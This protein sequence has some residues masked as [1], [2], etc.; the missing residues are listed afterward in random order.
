MMTSTQWTMADSEEIWAAVPPLA[1]SRG[2][3]GV[4]ESAS[5]GPVAP[6]ACLPSSPELNI[7]K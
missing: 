5:A 7:G 4:R 6:V 3:H 2:V 1:M